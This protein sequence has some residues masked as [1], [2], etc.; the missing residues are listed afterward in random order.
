M[1]LALYNQTK[2]TENNTNQS[3]FIT[4][5]QN[6]EN[7]RLIELFL[8]GGENKFDPFK[9]DNS[10]NGSWNVMQL[11]GT[12][13]HYITNDAKYIWIDW[14]NVPYNLFDT[15]TSRYIATI[16]YTKNNRLTNK[17]LLFRVFYYVTIEIFLYMC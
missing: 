1:I 8:T 15:S 14:T 9:H 5:I 11:S 2:Q 7:G 13:L 3:A 10:Y 6:A 12:N 16:Q 17:R 4:G